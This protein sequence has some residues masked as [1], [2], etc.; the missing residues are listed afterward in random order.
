NTCSH[1]SAMECLLHNGRISF[2][3]LPENS[4]ELDS[5]SASGSIEPPPAHNCG[6]DRRFAVRSAGRRSMAVRT[7]TAVDRSSSPGIGVAKVWPVA[8]Y[9]YLAGIRAFST[10]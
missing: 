5:P 9:Y 4:S 7:H 10:G 3:R 2:L 8:R 6:L 1:D